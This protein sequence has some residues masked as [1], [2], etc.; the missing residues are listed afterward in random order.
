MVCE[1]IKSQVL[2]SEEEK[3]KL[4]KQKE[5]A[6]VHTEDLEKVMSSAQ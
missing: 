3:R 4:K 1:D 6:D 5:T 2:L